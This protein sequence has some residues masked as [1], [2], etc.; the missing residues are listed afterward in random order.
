MNAVILYRVYH[1]GRRQYNQY[2]PWSKF[3]VG[4]HQARLRSLVWYSVSPYCST[5]CLAEGSSSDFISFRCQTILNFYY[6]VLS[7]II[8]YHIPSSL[9]FVSA[10]GVVA[11]VVIVFCLF[12]LGTF[13]DIGFRQ[14]G[15]LVNWSGIPFAIGVYGFCY[16][17]HSV[18]PNIYQSMA[19]KTKFTKALIVW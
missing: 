15:E 5:N 1:F 9:L 18:F 4:R 19:D 2:I 12:F 6:L 17:G 13:G 7:M 11:T 16:S 14:N 8:G 10:C 3:G